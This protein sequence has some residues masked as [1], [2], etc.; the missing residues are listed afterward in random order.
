M[1]TIM[2]HVASFL[3]VASMICLLLAIMMLLHLIQQAFDRS[4][5]IWGLIAVVFPPGT[6][7]YCRRT[8]DT[9]HTRFKVIT[10]LIIAAVVLW[11][12]AMVF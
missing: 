6:Y 1:S 2:A 8:W 11:L 3:G 9:N 12:L 4:G 7:Y 10:G 5:V